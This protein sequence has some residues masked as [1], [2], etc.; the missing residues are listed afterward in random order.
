MEIS[1]LNET[2]IYIS[3]HKALSKPPTEEETD[4]LFDFV[5]Y[6]VKDLTISGP[7]MIRLLPKAMK[8]TLTTGGFKLQDQSIDSRYEGRSFVDVCRTIAHELIHYNQK[9]RGEF[10]SPDYVHQD[11]G[12]PMED[13][14]N[15]IAG[16][17]IKKYVRD[18]NARFIYGL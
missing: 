5:E 9:E 3:Y 2:P 16:Q 1:N 11:I 8:G 10:D 6:C 17:L 4:T 13:E 7:V 14:A 12:G 15:A 18:R